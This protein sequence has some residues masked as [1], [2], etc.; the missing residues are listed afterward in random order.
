MY[1][2]YFYTHYLQ[3]EVVYNF[4]EYSDFI[5]LVLDNRVFIPY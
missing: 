5:T 2:I 1:Q 4:V 3:I